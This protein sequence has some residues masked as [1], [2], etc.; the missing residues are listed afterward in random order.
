MTRS[1]KFPMTRRRLKRPENERPSF[2]GAKAGN[3]WC[4]IEDEFGISLLLEEQETA[5]RFIGLTSLYSA[6]ANK[7]CIA[8]ASFPRF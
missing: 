3:W 5:K 1:S 4:R 8:D 2:A 7:H 6:Q